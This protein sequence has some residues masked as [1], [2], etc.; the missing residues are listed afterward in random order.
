MKRRYAF[1]A[2]TMLVLLM[3]ILCTA[4]QQSSPEIVTPFKEI[5]AKHIASY[6]TN[7]R[8]SPFKTGDPNHLVWRKE[9]FDAEP[10]YSVDVQST[11]SLVSPY[12]GIFEFT[13]R[14]YLTKAWD[15]KEEAEKD[16]ASTEVLLVKHKH[17][18]AYQDRKWVP[19][20]R[21]HYHEFLKEWFDCDE[22]LPD[23]KTNIFGC[24]EA[25]TP[26]PRP[27]PTTKTQPPRRK[28]RP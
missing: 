8:V 13:L 23:G 11:N 10:K 9:W 19:T 24:L 3:A 21:K 14:R 26:L 15:T 7:H 5:A 16:T 18:F 22:V 20:D 17:I 12:V 27:T 4:T 28:P 1:V 25:V 6:Q 2:S